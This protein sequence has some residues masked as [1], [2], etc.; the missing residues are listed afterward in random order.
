MTT[1]VPTVHRIEIAMLADKLIEQA[2]QLAEAYATAE[3]CRAMARLTGNDTERANL[4][5]RA[6]FW[7][8]TVCDQH[9][10]L[11]FFFNYSVTT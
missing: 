11:N 4:N 6:D 10:K 9:A 3:T 2:N 1:I 8:A 5:A 7:D